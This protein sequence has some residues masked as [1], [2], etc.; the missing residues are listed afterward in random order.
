MC[1]TRECQKWVNKSHVHGWRVLLFR[2]EVFVGGGGR[3]EI[4][5]ASD[6]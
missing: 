5:S 3:E 1:G 6:F 2:E 4:V